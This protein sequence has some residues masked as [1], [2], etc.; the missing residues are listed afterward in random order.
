[1]VEVAE[2]MVKTPLEST[3]CIKGV[4]STRP[5]DQVNPVSIRIVIYIAICLVFLLYL[6]ILLLFNYFV[7]CFAEEHLQYCTNEKHS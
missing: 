1:M 6:C 7:F 2:V 5:A 3:I 4:V